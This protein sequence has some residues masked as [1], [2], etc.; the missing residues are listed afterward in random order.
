ME[1]LKAPEELVKA[2]PEGPL[3]EFMAGW[4][5]YVLLIVGAL[6]VLLLLWG[7]MRGLMTR[8]VKPATE[9]S[10]E[11]D[12]SRY[13]APPPRTGDRRLLVE[14][15]P[16]RIRLVVVAPSGAQAEEELD[17]DNLGRLLERILPGL[18]AVYQEDRPRVKLWPR[19]VSYQGFA[20]HFHQCMLVPEEEG[21]LSP[22]VLVAGRVKLKDHQ[23]MLGL[24]L[25]ALKPTTLGQQTLDAHEWTSVL[26]VRMRD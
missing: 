18:G 24:A 23:M 25:V 17:L 20:R 4:G 12:L 14:G 16:V 2:M 11:E 10:L 21:E 6:L 15:V 7:L 3:R 5:W 13:P 19:Q 9:R 1:I 22:W 8:K 26:R